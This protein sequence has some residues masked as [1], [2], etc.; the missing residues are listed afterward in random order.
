M[1]PET[2]L[3]WLERIGMKKVWRFLRSMKFGMAL[4][5]LITV[6]SLAG[7]LIQQGNDAAYYMAA[8]PGIGGAILA[9]QLDDVF[10]SWYFISLMA[11]LCLNLLLCSILRL[12]STIA[13]AKG[14]AEQVEKAEVVPTGSEKL[15]RIETLLKNRRMKERQAKKGRVYF[16]NSI[17]FYGSFVTHLGLLF[18]LVFAGCAMW[19]AE[20]EDYTLFAGDSVKLE[21]GTKITLDAFRP[22]DDE[23]RTDYIST[24]RVVDQAGNE[25]GEQEIRVNHP[26]NFGGHKYFQQNYGTAGSMTVTNNGLSNDIVLDSE[27]FLSLDGQNGIAFHGLY[28]DHTVDEN[29]QVS[30][31]QNSD[32]VNPIYLIDLVKDGTSTRGVG[33]PGE[34]MEVDGVAYRFNAPVNYSGIRVKTLPSAVLGALYACFVLLTAGL[35]MCFFMIPVYVRI[36]GKGY[37]LYSP[38]KS[39][40]ISHEISLIPEDANESEAS[41]K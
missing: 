35:Y 9:L 23:G 13:Q 6:C 40:D 39:N 19:L 30:L 26:L 7:S 15:E 36:T 2:K 34:I 14:A 8:Y 18:V 12:K 37:A 41:A 32:Y 29:G 22:T 1:N 20:V 31:I 25:S 5:V 24:I 17:G 3:D 27:M 28:P 38:K 33:T 16:K 10:A 11:L 4:L 21:D